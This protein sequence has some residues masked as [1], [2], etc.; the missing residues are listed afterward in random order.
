MSGFGNDLKG[1]V[2]EISIRER[3]TCFENENPAHAQ[4]NSQII[5]TKVMPNCGNSQERMNDIKTS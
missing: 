3:K 4:E 5:G 2:T 1:Q